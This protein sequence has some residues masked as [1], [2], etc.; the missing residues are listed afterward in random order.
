MKW[1]FPVKHLSDIKHE[2]IA[3][4]KVNSKDAVDPREMFCYIHYQI[5]HGEQKMQSWPYQQIKETSIT[6]VYQHLENEVELNCRLSSTS[7]CCGFDFHCVAAI[8][9]DSFVQVCFHVNGL[10]ATNC[11]DSKKNVYYTYTYIII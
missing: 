7:V 6:L 3:L 4:K 1:G 2:T 9:I 10:R 8:Y 11:S 5:H